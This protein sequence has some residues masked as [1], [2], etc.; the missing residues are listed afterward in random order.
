[1][2]GIL[3]STLEFDPAAGLSGW[4]QAVQD[5]GRE[6]LRRALV[7]AVRTDEQMPPACP[8]GGRA[9][10]RSQGTVRRQGL[11]W[12]GRVA[13]VLRRQ[14]GRRNY[15]AWQAI[16]SAVAASSVRWPWSSSGG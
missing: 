12:F 1:M 6:A 14:R 5:A 9:P 8:H 10:S 7:Q 15:D 16:P 13:L 4:E 11:T 3:S 2:Q